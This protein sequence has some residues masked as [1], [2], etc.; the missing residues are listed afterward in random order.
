MS[1]PCPYTFSIDKNKSG[2][3]VESEAANLEVLADNHRALMEPVVAV[4]ATTGQ[5]GP[6]EQVARAIP[7]RAFS[8]KVLVVRDCFELHVIVPVGR[9]PTRLRSICSVNSLPVSNSRT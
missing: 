6:E 2:R 9:Q 3:L 7:E 1:I 4:K 5:V 8:A